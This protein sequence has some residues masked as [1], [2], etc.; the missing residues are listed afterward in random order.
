MARR[1]SGIYGGIFWIQFT[2]DGKRHWESSG[3]QF[4]ADA[5]RLLR[6]RLDHPVDRKPTVN[7]LLDRLIEDYEIRKRDSYKVAS[8]L[9]PVR[10]RLGHMK[11]VDV[12]K[13]VIHCYQRYRLQQHAA[14]GTVNRECQMLRQALNKIACPE[15]ISRPIVIRKL[16]ESSPSRFL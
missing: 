4:Q 1:S 16:T 6:K 13:D 15:I 7:D 9:K 10:S 12:D 14:H 5:E 2:V 11:A 8:H 3:S